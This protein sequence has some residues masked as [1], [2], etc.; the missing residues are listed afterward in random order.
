MANVVSG[1]F[2]LSPEQ[3]IQQQQT[4]DKQEAAQLGALMPAGYGAVGYGMSRLGSGAIRGLSEVFGMGDPTLMKAR[5]IE[6]IMKDTQSDLGANADPATVYQSLYNRLSD[7][8]YSNEAMFALDARQK[9]LDNQRTF[10][11]KQQEVDAAKAQAATNANI[12]TADFVRK[13]AVQENK[14]NQ[15]NLQ[16]VIKDYN[17]EDSDLYKQTKAWGENFDSAGWFE[18]APDDPEAVTNALRSLHKELMQLTYVDEYGNTRP[19]LKPGEAMKAAQTIL[20]EKDDKGEL[21]Y[22]KKGNW[23]P[24]VGTEVTLPSDI[25]SEIKTWLMD[26]AGLI[27]YKDSYETAPEWLTEADD[28]SM[29]NTAQERLKNN[30]NDST[31]LNAINILR[32]QK[33]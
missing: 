6:Q 12:K 8:G 3:V 17:N 14:V 30:P 32:N 27:D 15:Q 7:K 1:L 24:F 25:K 19:I 11:L 16:Q 20:S 29:W 23:N 18:F 5:D 13:V 4:M 2:G 9:Y 22:V 21:K 26:Q 28:I 33:K 10:D 31:A